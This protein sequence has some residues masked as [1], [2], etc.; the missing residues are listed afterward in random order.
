MYIYNT[1]LYLKRERIANRIAGKVKDPCKTAR[2]SNKY[3]G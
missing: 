1:Y 3:S 2:N